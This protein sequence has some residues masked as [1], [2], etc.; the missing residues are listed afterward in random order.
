MQDFFSSWQSWMSD[1][2]LLQ[3]LL[4]LWDFCHPAHWPI[5]GVLIAVCCAFEGLHIFIVS[6]PQ[7]SF[8]ELCRRV[9][10]AVWRH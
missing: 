4:S 8:T 9:S 5:Y 6:S 7:P 1:Q 2:W 10:R 3:V